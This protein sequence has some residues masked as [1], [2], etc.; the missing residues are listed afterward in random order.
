[1]WLIRYGQI[2]FVGIFNCTTKAEYLKY[3][4]FMFE[5]C[6]KAGNDRFAKLNIEKT[7]IMQATIIF[8]MEGLSFRHLTNKQGINKALSTQTSNLNR[9]Y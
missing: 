9:L 8:D 4:I 2:D 7:K 6:I 3:I 1:M 5:S